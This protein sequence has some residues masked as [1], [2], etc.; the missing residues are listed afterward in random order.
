MNAI[1]NHQTL[2]IDRLREQLRREPLREHRY[3]KGGAQHRKLPLKLCR[4]RVIKRGR[5][6]EIQEIHELVVWLGRLYLNFVRVSVAVDY[7]HQ[8][9]ISIIHRL[10]FH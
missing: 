8:K 9:T 10:W 7:S 4:R 1:L 2:G 5:I 6:H 3:D